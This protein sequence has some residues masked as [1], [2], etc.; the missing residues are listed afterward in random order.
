MKVEPDPQIVTEQLERAGL[1]VARHGLPAPLAPPF[2]PLPV[3]P[4][5][6][7]AV[8]AAAEFDRTSGLLWRAVHSGEVV[9]D[10]SCAE[11]VR[12]DLRRGFAA[13][14]QMEAKLVS[15]AGALDSRGVE[16]A[17]LKGPALAHLDYPDPT[18]RLFGDIDLLIGGVSWSSAL[19]LLGELG[20]ARQHGELSDRFTRRFGKGATLIDPDG[21]EVDLHL[22]FAEG[23]FGIL[24]DPSGL[25]MTRGVL[26]IAGRDVPVLDRTGRLVHAAF[27]AALGGF[28]RYRAFRDVVQLL[29]VGADW[30]AAADWAGDRRVDVVLAAAFEEAWQRLR[31]DPGHPAIDWA[32]SIVPDRAEQR[33]LEV[34][35]TEQP[36]RSKVRTALPILPVHRR[37][38]LLAPLLVHKLRRPRA[39]EDEV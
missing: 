36:Y 5:I 23:R 28:R 24:G 37:I 18:W 33:A 15:L 25:R 3:D 21:F 38:G 13:A 35:A 34:F 12:D 19:E 32:R 20:L 8:R 6:F 10:E 2:D 39:A 27:H 30:E 1:V 4:E 7:G 9:V 31:L 14:V 29:V 16:W 17:L 22:R 26:R 11:L